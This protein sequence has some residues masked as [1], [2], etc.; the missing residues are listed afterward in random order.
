MENT[1]E[2][3]WSQRKAIKIN[4]MLHHNGIPVAH[5]RCR[6]LGIEG[7]FVESGP[8]T[9]PKNTLLDLAFLSD[10]NEITTRVK[11]MVI[12]SSGS[13]L[14]LRFT[15]FGMDG[16]RAVKKVYYR[17]ETPNISPHSRSHR[18]NQKFTQHPR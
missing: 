6:D 11:V 17:D 4:V 18:P 2:N 13:G 7:V 15:N 1:M 9:Y 8:L 14:G 5:C 3:R 12:H 16:L 10:A